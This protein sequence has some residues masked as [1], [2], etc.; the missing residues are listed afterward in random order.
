LSVC[1]SCYS[2]NDDAIH[3]ILQV[4]LEHIIFRRLGG[5]RKKAIAL[6]NNYKMVPASIHAE[7]ELYRVKFSI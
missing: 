4:A 2:V 1:S 3:K 5:I 7:G 6:W